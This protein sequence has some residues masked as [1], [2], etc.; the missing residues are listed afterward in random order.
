MPDFANPLAAIEINQIDGELHKKG[1]DRLARDDPQALA[2][3]QA[4]VLEETGT[5]R[6]AVAGHTDTLP[7]NRVSGVI[8][9]SDGQFPLNITQPAQIACQFALTEPAEIV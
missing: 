8:P 4:P 7:Q 5:A 2:L 1:V 3:L 9:H 6:R